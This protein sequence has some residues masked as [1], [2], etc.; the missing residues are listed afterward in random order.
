MKL[1]K[2]PGKI[3]VVKPGDGRKIVWQKAC[4]KKKSE[5]PLLAKAVNVSE[6]KVC[7]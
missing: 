2:L 3:S 6:A 5:Y 7:N 1:F 4:C